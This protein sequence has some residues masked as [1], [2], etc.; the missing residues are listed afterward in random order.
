MAR[1]SVLARPL[2]PVHLK[3]GLAQPPQAAAVT[4]KE[5]RI[6]HVGSTRQEIIRLSSEYFCNCG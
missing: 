6:R 3:V 2:L 4:G 1:V 5:V